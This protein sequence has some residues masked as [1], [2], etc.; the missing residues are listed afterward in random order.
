MNCYYYW[1]ERKKGK[2]QGGK[3]RNTY[4]KRKIKRK[5]SQRKERSG[6]EKGRP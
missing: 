1:R 5:K 6:R 4:D 3:L 2:A